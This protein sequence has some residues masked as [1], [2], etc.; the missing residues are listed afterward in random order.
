L[1]LTTR[2]LPGL[3]A[4]GLALTD[5]AEA[6][7]PESAR[8][9]PVMPADGARVYEVEAPADWADLAGAYPL[10]VSKSRRHCWEAVSGFAGRWLIPDFAAVA[11]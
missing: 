5:D 6:L 11:I 7:R 8:C 9:W 1:P 4:V 2:R 3:G 10:E